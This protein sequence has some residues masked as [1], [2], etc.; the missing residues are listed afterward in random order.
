[1]PL[2]LRPTKYSRPDWD[3]IRCHDSEG[4]AYPKIT[5]FAPTKVCVVL[6]VSRK[7]RREELERQRERGHQQLNRLYRTTRGRSRFV[8]FISFT[9]RVVVWST[10]PYLFSLFYDT[11]VFHCSCSISFVFV[12]F[13]CFSRQKCCI[14]T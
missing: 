1:M 11:I 13:V 3:S 10:S 8:F 12:L 4:K 14:E 5:R 2:L 6:D 7:E 9:T